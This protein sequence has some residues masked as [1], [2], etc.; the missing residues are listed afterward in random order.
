MV[1]LVSFYHTHPRL[2]MTFRKE[3]PEEFLGTGAFFLQASPAFVILYVIVPVPTGGTAA[4]EA[5]PLKFPLKKVLFYSGLILLALVVVFLVI[6][7]LLHLPTLIAGLRGIADALRA[8]VLGCVMAYLLYP[9]TRFAEQFLLYH[10]V[11]KR[12]AR[13][14]STTF[15]T[16]VLLALI[17]LFA[18]FIIPQ[19]VFNLPPLVQS[20]PGMITDF[21][22]QLSEYLASHGQS[23][24]II[25]TISEKLS[26]SFNQWLQAD[27]LSA[28]VDLA[29][30]VASV[31]KGLL[32][33]IIGIIVMVYLLMSRD[34]FIGQ[35]KKILFALCRKRSTCDV[36]LRHL[37]VINRI[38]SGFVSGKLLDSLII[39]I[40]CGVCLSLLHMPYAMLISVIVGIT[41]IIPVFG[42]FFGALPSAFILLLTDPGKC[43]IFILFIIILQQVDGNIIGPKI[44]GDSTGLSAFWVLFA[45]LLF[46]HL[47]G[48]WGMLLGVP[49]FASFYYL[50][51]EFINSRLRKKDLPLATREYVHIAGIDDN[52]TI[53]YMP[54]PVIQFQPL[55][56]GEDSLWA[57]LRRRVK[58]GKTPPTDDSA[59]HTP[60]DDSSHPPDP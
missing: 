6:Q 10:R 20:L 15:S 14:L 57:R 32:N 29:G 45:L 19:L 26:A 28:L 37:R 33:F 50:L 54:P 8:I 48:F 52:G 59:P 7:A 23:A 31:A 53:S 36:I 38:F 11:S 47:M 25:I 34:Q 30:R 13:A 49:L 58:Q 27:P 42:P 40:I 51:R 22:Q 12:A 35:G 17:V 46:N 16:C 21:S 4:K 2:T 1:I 39:G 5:H 41:N 44:L 24:Q 9:L 55:F 3:Q 56:R 18:Y 43:L 60:E